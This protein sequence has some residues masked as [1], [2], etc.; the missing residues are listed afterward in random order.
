MFAER[1]QLEAA[2]DAVCRRE[3]FTARRVPEEHAGGKWTLRYESA[4]G[5]GGN[6]EVDL[7]FIFRVPLWPVVS[8]DS[9]AVGSYKAT[10]VPVVEEHELAAGKL[11]ALL[12]RRASRD[13]FDAHQLLTR[14]GFDGD[15]LR[16]AFVIYGAV[17]RRDWRTVSAN[18][19]NFEAR[20]LDQL[21]PLIREDALPKLGPRSDWAERLVEDCR[22]R[23]S[24]VLPL[25]GAEREFLDRLLDHGEIEPS[26]LTED[27]EL[28][29]RI[30][31][32]PGL[33]WKALNVRQ[34]KGR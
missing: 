12:A 5:Q 24:I 15:R 10:Q 23:L 19:V 20:E 29:E 34:F 18:D 1:P 4:L 14:V 27:A 11:A 6:L 16:L 9:R 13:L 17:N 33:E 8:R 32:H 25:A 7:N 31:R 3:G 21:V 28:A 30:R 22:Q 26:L 2:I